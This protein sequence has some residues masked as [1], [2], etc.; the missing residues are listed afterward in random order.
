MRI[1]QVN[2]TLEIMLQV[3]L[4]TSFRLALKHSAIFVITLNCHTEICNRCL[5]PIS[6]MYTLQCMVALI[7]LRIHLIIILCIFAYQ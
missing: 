2:A 7:E 1:P 6:I 4:I 5:V 3:H